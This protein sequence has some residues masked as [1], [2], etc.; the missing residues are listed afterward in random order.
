MPKKSDLDETQ[1]IVV[2]EKPSAVTLRKCS[3]T[4]TVPE[5]PIADSWREAGYEDT[6]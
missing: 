5:G 1:E 4:V 2:E 3:A 6:K